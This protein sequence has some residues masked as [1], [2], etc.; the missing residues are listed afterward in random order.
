[1]FIRLGQ[2]YAFLL[3]LICLS[4]NIAFFPEVREP[5][6]GSDDPLESVKTAL[7]KLEI[8]AKHTEDVQ[9]APAPA[10]K[11]QK[12]TPEV[13][14]DDPKPK[15]KE[16]DPIPDSL[17]PDPPQKDELKDKPKTV[18]D[19]EKPKEPEKPKPAAPVVAPMENQQIAAVMP[20]PKPADAII[21]P[22]VAEQFKPVIASP[23]PIEIAKPSTNAVWDTVDTALERPIRY[24]R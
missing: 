2:F 22:V 11:E 13:P 3:L 8:V 1:M 9:E 5:F 7:S 18:P 17:L 20:M 15:P 12:K 16:S 19:V 10:P 24:D 23:K 6:L 14:A 21:Q 4:V